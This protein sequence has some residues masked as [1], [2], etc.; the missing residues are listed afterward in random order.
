MM[1]ACAWYCLVIFH[2]Y[3]VNQIVK[4]HLVSILPNS[5]LLEYAS[6]E[7]AV[8]CI[9]RRLSCS[10]RVS[11]EKLLSQVAVETPMVKAPAYS[12]Y[13]LGIASR[14]CRMVS[15]ASSRGILESWNLA[16]V[17]C[18]TVA[19]Q[20]ATHQQVYLIPSSWERGCK[21]FSTRKLCDEVTRE[22]TAWN[23]AWLTHQTDGPFR[24]GPS[25]TRGKTL[26]GSLRQLTLADLLANNIYDNGSMWN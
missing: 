14:Y 25:L 21:L 12:W 20:L 1:P 3:T 5:I 15:V 19:L 13:T 24:H 18:D 11:I 9:E 6:I 10:T 23:K 2:K 8:G 16:K 22:S 26:K 17:S 4:L 7:P